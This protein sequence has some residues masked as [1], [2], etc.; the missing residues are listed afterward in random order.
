MNRFLVRAIAL[1][2]AFL[3]PVIASTAPARAADNDTYFTITYG[4]FSVV[5]GGDP[6]AKPP[7]ITIHG[8]GVGDNGLFEH[9]SASFDQTVVF[10]NPNQIKNGRFTFTCIDGSTLTG[11]YNGPTSVPDSKGY[12]AGSGVF[13]ITGGSGRFLN[14]RGHGTYTVLAQLLQGTSPVLTTFSGEIER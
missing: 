7:Y 8:T 14:A 11:T 2:A 6:H 10:S 1:G 5:T 13:T 4:G 3:L 9:S 12:T